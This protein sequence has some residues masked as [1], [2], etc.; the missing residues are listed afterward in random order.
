MDAKWGWRVI[1]VNCVIKIVIQVTELWS[2]WT[3]TIQTFMRNHYSLSLSKNCS[4][5]WVGFRRNFSFVCNSDVQNARLYSW[6]FA[7]RFQYTPW[8]TALCRLCVTPHSVCMLLLASCKAVSKCT[9]ISQCLHMLVRNTYIGITSYLVLCK[10]SRL[11]G[12]V[13]GQEVKVRYDKL[14]DMMLHINIAKDKLKRTGC[15]PTAVMEEACG[16]DCV[17]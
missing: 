15:L 1:G 5:C 4:C 2:D 11:W 6:F 7:R 8:K 3:H 12:S 13:G 14:N 17:F 10:V 16:T 9:T